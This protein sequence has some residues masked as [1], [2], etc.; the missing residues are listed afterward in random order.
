MQKPSGPRSRSAFRDKYLAAIGTAAILLISFFADAQKFQYPNPGTFGTG[1]HRTAND[2]TL[3][4]PTA[5]G[6]PTDATWLFSQGFGGAGQK[7]K[8]AAHYYDSCGHHEYVWDPALQAWHR[9]DSSSGSAGGYDSTIM[10]PIYRSDTA[11]QAIRNSISLKADTTGG[12]IRRA[13]TANKWVNRLANNATNDSIIYYI[14]NTRY[15]IKDNGSGGGGSDSGIAVRNGI[16]ATRSGSAPQRLLQV[17]SSAYATIALLQKKIDS[18]NGLKDSVAFGNLITVTANIARLGGVSSQSNT[19]LGFHD[20]D[21]LSLDSLKNLK[22]PHLQLLTSSDRTYIMV[23]DT[24]TG[25]VYNIPAQRADTTGV[26]AI[27]AAGGTPWAYFDPGT[28]KVKFQALP[29]GPWIKVGNI[30][31]TQAT[32]DTVQVGTVTYPKAKVNIGGGLQVDG[33]IT[34]K[35][36]I[37]AAGDSTSADT[38]QVTQTANSN[39]TAHKHLITT[40]QGGNPTLVTSNTINNWDW[41]NA[42]ISNNGSNTFNTW[43]YRENAAGGSTR[44]NVVNLYNSPRVLGGDSLRS[45]YFVTYNPLNPTGYLGSNG[46]LHMSGSGYYSNIHGAYGMALDNFSVNGEYSGIHSIMGYA[47][48][49]FVINATG[50]AHSVLNWTQLDSIKLQRPIFANGTASLMG[51]GSTDSLL[52]KLNLGTNLSI[53]GNTLNATS[54][55]GS[56]NLQQTLLLGNIATPNIIDSN[57][58]QSD[59]VI[60][61]NA[62]LTGNV[63]VGDTIL[64]SPPTWYVYGSSGSTDPGLNAAIGYGRATM[65]FRQIALIDS[66]LSGTGISHNQGASALA[67]RTAG[68]PT[69]VA[70]TSFLWS[71]DAGINDAYATDSVAYKVDL[72][73]IIDTLI[74]AR[75]WPASR[76]LIMSP[77]YCPVRLQDSAFVQVDQGICATKGVPFLDVWHPFQT[78]YKGGQLIIYSDSLHPSTAGQ[79]F[80]ANLIS[81][82]IKFGTFQGNLRVF[83]SDTIRRNHIVLGSSSTYGITF[84]VGGFEQKAKDSSINFM[85]QPSLSNG[86][87]LGLVLAPNPAQTALTDSMEMRMTVNTGAA[88]QFTIGRRAAGALTPLFYASGANNLGLGTTTLQTGYPLTTSGAVYVGG[89]Q[90]INGSI[91]VVADNTYDAQRLAFFRQSNSVIAMGVASSNDLQ[92]GNAFGNVDIGQISPGDGT[93]FQNIRFRV[94]TNGRILV[95]TTTDNTVDPFQVSGTIGVT[96][97]NIVGDALYRPKYLPLYSGS[98]NYIGIGLASTNETQI[99]N[100]FGPTSFGSTASSVFTEHSQFNTGA[101]RLSINTTDDAINALNVNGRGKF[102]DTLKLPNIV[103][104]LLDSANFKPMVVDGSG[105]IFKTD[106][107]TF[108]S[109]G[110]ANSDSVGN[111]GYTSNGHLYKVE[112]SL[113]AVYGAP[114]WGTYTSTLTNTTNVSGSA[115]TGAGYTK[116]G[117]C[118][119]AFVTG[120]ISTTAGSNTA[121]TLTVSIPGSYSPAAS[122]VYCGN[123][124]IN[125]TGGPNVVG[126]VATTGGSTVTFTF[127]SP[128]VLSSAA[129]QLSFDY[130]Y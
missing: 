31:S 45:G 53:T 91:K 63:Q 119:H 11:K 47:V 22:I 28:G 93:T 5:C 118:V 3:Y 109:G 74:I 54:G 77:W 87:Y 65:N 37:T 43:T 104:K 129:F 120:T 18:L 56:Q 115:F 83:G 62:R 84:P 99:S 71:V 25:L 126:I 108:G 79:F 30:T 57:N 23:R 70:G 67:N 60:S 125:I 124:A 48:G 88:S 107:A 69:Y 112:D 26:A 89:K 106:W 92:I 13:D 122:A 36:T 102:T 14:G 52:G 73:K 97:L 46:I 105:N 50:G 19:S 20:T 117:N 9:V 39:V 90:Y 38:L 1:Q 81:N 4:F 10:Q 72:A 58:I 66:A 35:T 29:I 76:L 78:A 130:F 8:Q 49:N 40:I 15:A 59:S 100:A 7:L 82:V 64:A 68:L 103:R 85:A 95:N 24:V 80:W 96:A 44:D 16:L 2:S 51:I 42:N 127:A 116:V 121:T 17:D 75:G 111:Q 41:T 101:T 110:K 12:V 86:D 27:I 33:P 34:G 123:G 114:A 55:G 98:G 113:K 32:T 6:V 94:Q 128:S 21:T 61:R